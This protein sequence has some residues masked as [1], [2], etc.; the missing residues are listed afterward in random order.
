MKVAMIDPSAFTIPYDDALAR[1]LAAR[2]H[3][4]R[5]YTRS[6][7]DQESRVAERYE[8]IPHFYRWSERRRVRGT[9]RLCV[10]GVEHVADMLRLRRALRRFAPDVIHVQ[11]MPVPGVDR[12]VF[13]GLGGA[14]PL[15]FTAHDTMPFNLAP[16]SRLQRLGW[17]ESLGAFDAIIV[18][19]RSARQ[20]LHARGIDA[21]RLAVVPHGLFSYAPVRPRTQRAQAPM[22]RVMMFGSVK[23][24]KGVDVLL[25]AVAQL[26][27]GARRQLRVSVVGAPSPWAHGLPAL[28]ERLGVRNEVELDLRY[29]PDEEVGQ[30]LASADVFAFPYREIEASGALMAAL[31]FARPIVASRLGLFAELLEDDVHGA[32]VP[33]EDPK[34]LAAAL[35]RLTSDPGL[36]GR[37]G[38]AVARLAGETPSWGTIAARTEEVYASARQRRAARAGVGGCERLEEER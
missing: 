26:P 15:V 6:L 38:T 3:E 12:H 33:P 20:R 4:V 35:A 32:L 5:L 21:A 29:V 2:G 24:Y 13:A 36:R 23:P 37:M 14:V 10:K 11:W 7:R 30:V 19:T 34:A 25:R 9:A 8:V 22:I 1:A 18:H 17:G 27:P 31:P 16:S 28:V